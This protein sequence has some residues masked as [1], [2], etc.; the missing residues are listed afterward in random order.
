MTETPVDGDAK[1]GEAQGEVPDGTETPVD[2]DAKLGEA[3]GEL[4]DV[5]ETPVDD[6]GQDVVEV[7]GRCDD[8]GESANISGGDCGNT[9]KV[10]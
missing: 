10:K 5:T 6:G 3:Q 2:G 1:P 7:K 4:P 9:L 8:E